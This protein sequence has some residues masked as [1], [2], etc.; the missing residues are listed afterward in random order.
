MA[1]RVVVMYNREEVIASRKAAG[2]AVN[3]DDPDQIQSQ[4]ASMRIDRPDPVSGDPG[5]ERSDAGARPRLTRLDVPDKT[6]FPQDASPLRD[7]KEPDLES[8][9]QNALKSALKSSSKIK[10]WSEPLHGISVATASSRDLRED[11]RLVVVAVRN[12]VNEPI[13]IVPGFPEITI[14]TRDD[15]DQRVLVEQVKK[16]HVASSGLGGEIPAAATVYY[17]LV[18][19][20]PILGARQH[21]RVAVGQINAADEPATTDLA[22]SAR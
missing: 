12:T 2:L 15:R 11:M 17:A 7:K 5:K 14:E 6:T 19:Q 9:A 13:R 21:L 4:I 8:E 18:Y 3:L 22:A 16:L 20:R 10:N 1:H